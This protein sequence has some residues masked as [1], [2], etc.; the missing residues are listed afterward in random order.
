[1]IR[2]ETLILART[3]ITN[4]EL[5]QIEQQF[6]KLSTQVKGSLSSFD[7]WGKFRLAYPV[8]KADYGVYVLAR[9]ELPEGNVEFVQ[10]ELNLF[11][12][13][14]CNEFVMRHVTVKLA[15]NAPV[16]YLKP[17]SVESRTPGS[18]DS[19]IKEHKMEGLIG[20]KVERGSRGEGRSAAWQN[21]EDETEG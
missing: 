6:Q 20:T 9:Y 11:F 16:N 17:E 15:P 5:D 13:I 19:F 8:N 21:T 1:M 4:D 14:K 7:K 10:K 3:E 12:K 18:V 2:Y